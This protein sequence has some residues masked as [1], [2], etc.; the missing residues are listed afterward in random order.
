MNSGDL[1]SFFYILK[2]E[3][4]TMYIIFFKSFFFISTDKYLKKIVKTC[5]NLLKL[6]AHGSW[7]PGPGSPSALRPFLGP[8]RRGAPGIPSATHRGSSYESQPRARVLQGSNAIKINTFL[9]FLISRI[10]KHKEFIW[11]LSVS[12]RVTLK[13]GI[14]IN[15]F[16]TFLI[17]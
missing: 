7:R 3:N 5:K 1:F 4:I 9:I 11:F 12:I 15:T 14:K 13:N 8:W 16:F 6:E 10:Q 2:Y 17:S